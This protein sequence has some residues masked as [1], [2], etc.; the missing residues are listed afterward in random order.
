[1]NPLD[2]LCSWILILALFFLFWGEPDVWDALHK[3][4]MSGLSA[5]CEK[6]P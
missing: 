6:T 1:M 4:A 2:T 5:T 3:Q